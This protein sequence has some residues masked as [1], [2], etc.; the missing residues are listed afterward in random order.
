MAYEISNYSPTKLLVVET[1]K[2]DVTLVEKATAKISAVGG[3]IILT[4]E[5][6][7]V[8]N[9]VKWKENFD[10][11]S[12]ASIED[13]VTTVDTW[14]TTS[15]GSGAFYGGWADYNDFATS[16][17]PITVTGGAGWVQ[18]TNDTVGTYTNTDH[19]P[20]DVTQLWD[21]ATD[22]FDFSELEVGDMVDIRLDIEITTPSN[23]TTVDCQ[24][25]LSTGA[26]AFTVHMITGQDYKTAG[27]FD[28]IVYNGIYMGSQDVIDN[29]GQVQ[30]QADKT[31]TVI[32]HGWYI[33]VTKLV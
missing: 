14:I 24:L 18:M 22:E 2:G 17:A 29:G 13:F 31:C 27:T 26:S 4:N 12:T 6:I 15:T 19:L 11:P 9:G 33:K 20:N 32:V 8:I 23:N 10:L 25:S 30:V 5:T 3:N 1:S 21:A 7:K 28:S 16:A